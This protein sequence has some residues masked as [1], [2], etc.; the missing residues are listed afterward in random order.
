LGK[1]SSLDETF[2]NGDAEESESFLGELDLFS[3]LLVVNVPENPVKVGA[4]RQVIHTV[5]TERPVDDTFHS[6]N[7]QQSFL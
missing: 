4:N 5:D 2:F 6:K 1:L 3:I 7:N